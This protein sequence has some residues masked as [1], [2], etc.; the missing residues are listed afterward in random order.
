MNDLQVLIVE[1]HPIQQR[2]LRLL[3]ESAG[4]SPLVV[5]NGKEA[6]KALHTLD[7]RL[8]LILMDVRMNEMDGL[9]CTRLIRQRELKTG[10]H[11]PIIAITAAA[12]YGDREK[13]LEAGM[14]DYLSKPFSLDAFR[15]KITMWLE[16]NN[17]HSTDVQDQRPKV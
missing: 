15:A 17:V 4:L 8:V 3:T 12:M 14:D 11:V 9:E 10:R 5:V 1:D 6:L 13:C 2:L 16:K 7:G